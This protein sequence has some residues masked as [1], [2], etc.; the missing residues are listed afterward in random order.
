MEIYIAMLRGINVSGQKKIKMADLR[1]HLSELPFDN[2]S[3]YI[4]SGNIVFQSVHTDPTILA[5]AIADKIREK[6]DFEVP[7]L[8]KT[9]SD[10]EAAV[11]NNPFPESE[12]HDLKYLH[13]TFLAEA[14]EASTIEHIQMLDFE[15]EQFVWLDEKIYLY[16]PKGYG[17]AK[18]TNNFWEKKLKI[19]ATTRNWK[20]VNKLL[21]MAQNL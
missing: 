10:F 3:T 19:A 5:K 14:P 18:M 20:T 11:E 12:G 6:Y 1:V 17:R 16:A 15:P 13:V 9:R 7:T 8:V 2:L 21:D 4:Q